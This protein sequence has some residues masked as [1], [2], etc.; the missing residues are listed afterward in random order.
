VPRLQNILVANR[1]EIAC[2]IIRTARALGY[3]TTAVYSHADA[4]SPHVQ[5][6]DLAVCLGPAPLAASYLNIAAILAAARG[7]GAD[8]VH[9]GYG[10]L[11]ENA[12]FARSCGAAGLTF[13]GPDPD[14]IAAMGDKRNARHAVAALG[15]PC[16]PGYDGDDQDDATLQRAAAEIG[17]PIMVKAAAG[18]GGRGMR[19]VAEPSEL[20]AALARAR[21]EAEKA[22]GDGR[23]IL[24]RAIDGARHVEVQVFGDRHGHVIHLGERDCSLQRRFQ[25]VIEESPCPAVDSS[26]RARLGEAAV[27]VARSCNYVGAGTVEL[28]LDRGRHFYFLEMNTRLQ[29]EHA[30]TE[31]VTGLDLVA[32]QIRIAEG[33]ALPLEQSEVSFQGHAIEARLYAE[34]PARGFVPQTGRIV[35]LALPTQRL[36]VDHALALGLTIGSHYDAMLAKLVAHGPDREAARL[37]LTAALDALRL[38]GVATNRV[39]LRRLLDEPRFVA[40]EATTDLLE[41]LPAPTPT[42]A[43]PNVRASAALALVLGAQVSSA[44]TPS[45]E[46]PVYPAALAGY[47]NSLG[48]SWPIRLGMDEREFNLGVDP[49]ADGGKTYLVHEGDS[50]RSVQVVA[51]GAEWLDLTIDGAARRFAWAICDADLY[52]QDLDGSYHFRDLTRAPARAA[53]AADS[54]QALAPM[55]G[56]LIAVLVQPGDLV[57]KGQA[58]AVVEA[59]KLELRVQADRAGRVSRVAVS[60]GSQV[61]ARQLLVEIEAG[62]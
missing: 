9:P 51:H 23:L 28:L 17:F 25:K 14:T 59:M 41:S 8:A 57:T 30:V 20:P 33:E 50:A 36:R 1:G 29:V 42:E 39:F 34:D 61:K 38:F 26:L 35:Q 2:R 53:R 45:A 4:D 62:S 43:D 21:S 32:W 3:R 31:C 22:F 27:R 54:G 40:G 16:V 44:E 10:L 58:V 5:Q 15:V 13:I 60:A 48:L 47:S 7:S 11:S 6:A 52:L 19:R 12:E 49:A 18:G 37:Q 55:D 56:T 24:E 46:R